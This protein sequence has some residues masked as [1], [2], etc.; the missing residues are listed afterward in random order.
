MEPKN[1]EFCLLHPISSVEEFL[2]DYFQVSGSKIKKNFKKAFLNRSLKEKSL[3]SL[4]INFVNNGE[5]NPTY[6]GSPL[7]VLFE[8]EDFFVFTK[9]PNQFIHPL[10]YDE[11]DNCLSFIRQMRPELLKVNI[12]NYDRGLLYRLD[13]E[14]SGVVIYV[15]SDSLYKEL[16]ENFSTAAKEKKYLAW[17]SGE[18]RLS[19]DFVHYFS[20]S[21]EKGKRVVVSDDPVGQA[22]ELSIL[23]LE[24]NVD[25]NQTLVEVML[26]SGLRHQIRAQMAHLGYPL[27]GDTFYGGPK[28]LRLYLH[29]LSYQIEA[30]GKQSFWV[31]KPIDFSGL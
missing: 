14:T 21:E 25:R 2:K 8:D 13:F 5:I 10:T 9:N 24:Y 28:A 19:G 23:A 22:G 1:I 29:A 6:A 27:I 11:S 12:D 31:S 3:L 30:R 26:K 18:M 20:A 15:K 4:P 16:R 7:E 17:V